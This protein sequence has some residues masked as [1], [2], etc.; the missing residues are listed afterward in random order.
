[1]AG[2]SGGQGSDTK[3][4][5]A[6]TGPGS[7]LT[8]AISSALQV[9]RVLPGESEASCDAELQVL[10]EELEADTPL[11]VYLVENIH[12]CL[13]W[14][15]RY[16]V[17]KRNAVLQKMAYLL[18]N[19]QPG[20]SSWKIPL[21]G[22]QRAQDRVFQQLGGD[23]IG[24]KIEALLQSAGTTWTSLQAD[25]M[26]ICQSSL[27]ALDERIAAQLKML[28]GLTSQYERLSHRQ[29]KQEF[30]RLQVENLRRDLDAVEHEQ[31]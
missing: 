5:K 16:R 24:P 31:P 12:E 19:R 6:A 13:L 2:R 15:R 18:L 27:L 28:Q 20:P 10:I 7:V 30:L 23:T 29:L 26:H 17:Q 14:I 25:A 4:R 3:H 1:M 22:N 8:G 9:A 11:K 21:D